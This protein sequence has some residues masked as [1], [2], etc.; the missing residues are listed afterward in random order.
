MHTIPCTPPGGTTVG[1]TACAR[2]GGASAAEVAQVAAR[3]RT[4][5]VGCTFV[6]WTLTARAPPHSCGERGGAAFSMRE[7]ARRA[8]GAPDLRGALLEVQ[9]LQHRE[10][11]HRLEPRQRGVGL[12][13]VQEEAVERRAVRG[14]LGP[15]VLEA[16]LA[17]RHLRERPDVQARVHAAALRAVRRR[18]EAKAH[19]ALA[20]RRAVGE[21][22]HAR[23]RHPARHRLRVQTDHRGVH[24]QIVSEAREPA[25]RI[26]GRSAAQSEPCERGCAN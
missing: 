26:S 12:L 23:R 1:S 18:V 20:R 19:H 25:G 9:R 24:V 4:L 13:V 6:T 21:R 14:R 8:G 5:A 17:D 3:T 7:I 2:H 15:A 16:R 22:D 10:P 11:A